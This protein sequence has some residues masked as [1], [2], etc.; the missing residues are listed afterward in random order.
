MIIFLKVIIWRIISVILTLL[1]TFVITGD[2]QSATQMTIVLHTILIL[3][4]YVFES[5]WNSKFKSDAS[6][7]MN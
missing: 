3:S 6:D 2:I 7:S 4:H 1:V 5:A